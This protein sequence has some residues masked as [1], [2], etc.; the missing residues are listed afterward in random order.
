MSPMTHIFNS[1]ADMHV[2]VYACICICQQIVPI[3]TGWS[4][5]TTVKMIFFS[6]L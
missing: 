2:H 4:L 6:V 3:A 5:W 1:L